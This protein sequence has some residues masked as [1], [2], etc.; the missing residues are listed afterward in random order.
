MASRLVDDGLLV[1]YY[2]H[3]D[4]DAWKALLEAGWEAA[5]LRVVN[6]FPI[7]TESAQ[8]VVK[9][10]KL[11]MDT[12]IVVVWRKGSSGSVDAARLY[13]ECIEAAAERARELM[14]LGIGGRDLFINVLAA[15]LAKATSYREV[16]AMGKLGTRELVENY[17]YPAA[18]LGLAR[19]FSRK[20]GLKDG[21]RSPDAML[22][23]L[24]KSLGGKVVESTDLRIFSI[25]TSM[26]A[27]AAITDL[28]LLLKPREAG[29]EEE[30]GAKVAKA[31]VYVLAEPSS[32]ERKA[33]EELLEKRGVGVL[34]P[35]IRCA[36]DALHILELFA[37]KHSVSEYT[38]KVEE[39]KAKHPSAVQEA[40]ALVKVLGEVLPEGDAERELCRRV[41][42]TALKTT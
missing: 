28:R 36:V 25:G 35:K 42:Q 31:K 8:S 41:F 20:A 6:A 7:T 22:Y 5:G 29:E 27:K 15:A 11:S 34:E 19:A 4:P 30:G 2:A 14:A 1:T 17:V 10:G 3:T 21:I 23:L 18:C 38:R 12:S 16:I 13:E 39:L 37:L 9:R 32:A 26:D 24:L 33:V 40:L